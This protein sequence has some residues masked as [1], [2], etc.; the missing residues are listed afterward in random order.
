MNEVGKERSIEGQVFI[1]QN[2]ILSFIDKKVGVNY[3]ANRNP[4]PSAADHSGYIANPKQTHMEL[5]RH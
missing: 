1:N 2:T 3:S 5:L 4:N